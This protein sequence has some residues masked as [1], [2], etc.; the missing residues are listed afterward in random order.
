[1]LYTHEKFPYRRAGGLGIFLLITFAYVGSV[2][3]YDTAEKL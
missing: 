1:M 2:L 3:C